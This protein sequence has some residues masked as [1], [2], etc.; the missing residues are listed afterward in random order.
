MEQAAHA[1]DEDD[2]GR[3]VRFGLPAAEPEPSGPEEETETGGRIARGVSFQEPAPTSPAAAGGGGSGAGSGGR[4]SWVRERYLRLY[5]HVPAQQPA[6]LYHLG[7]SE[8]SMIAA[9]GAVAVAVEEETKTAGAADQQSPPAAT[10]AV[11]AGAGKGEKWEGGKGGDEAD[12]EMEI[13]PVGLVRVRVTVCWRDRCL[14]Q[15]PVFG[16]FV[17]DPC[18]RLTV[19]DPQPN[20]TRR[21]TAAGRA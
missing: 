10:A 6:L 8:S 1:R 3:N 13:G 21:C 7:R 4:V 17:P 16:C 15:Q 12:L 14:R 2:G 19:P 18:L 20:P 5:P 11:G 9:P